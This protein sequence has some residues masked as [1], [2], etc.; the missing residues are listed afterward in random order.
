MPCLFVREFHEKG[1]FTIT[2]VVTP[3]CE[4]VLAGDG[5]ASRKWDGTAC[6]VIN[7]A[8]YK[9][10]DAK[11]GKAP[12]EGAIPCDPAPDLV[13]GHWPHWILIGPND[14]WHQAAW[15]AERTSLEDGTYELVGPKVN[16]NPESFTTHQLIKHGSSP[17]DP[18]RYFE[19]LKYYLGAFAIE[20][21]VFTHP[22]GRMCKI[23]RDDFGFEWPVKVEK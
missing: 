20:G 8:L 17:L 14:K 4:W 3:G 18:P 7:G 21:I 10:Y 22:D 23:R 1:K 12:P 2:E 11:A 13:T 9:R 16:A 19:E 15:E 5:T 6:A